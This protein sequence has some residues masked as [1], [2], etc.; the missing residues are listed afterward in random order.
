MLAG[1]FMIQTSVASPRMGC[2]RTPPRP[3]PI[4]SRVPCPMRG[5][6]Y[7]S[8]RWLAETA[9][10]DV[11]VE[12]TGF[13]GGQLYASFINEIEPL[14]RLVPEYSDTCASGSRNTCRRVGFRGESRQRVNL[15]SDAVVKSIWGGAKFQGV[16]FIF[17]AMS[18][19]WLESKKSMVPKEESRE[20]P[21]AF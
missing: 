4:S 3:S 7:D 1:R 8:Q 10:C 16:P 20:L 6:G 12:T 15:A 9:V 19:R 2:R 5:L 11:F 18:R 14:P 17:Y 21:Q 13:L